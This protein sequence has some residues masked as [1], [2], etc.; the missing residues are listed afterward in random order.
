MVF[1]PRKLGSSST[2]FDPRLLKNEGESK[3]PDT[4]YQAAIATDAR[5]GS[6]R[7]DALAIASETTPRQRRTSFTSSG[8]TTR[9]NVP[10]QNSDRSSM[11]AAAPNSRKI[12][13]L[14]AGPPPWLMVISPTEILKL[15]L[16]T[17][18]T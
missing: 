9:G 16:S 13:A 8:V 18:Y 12:T 10:F 2:T 1:A 17:S 4:W 3:S 11:D 15:S 5:E 14:S 7:A 6:N